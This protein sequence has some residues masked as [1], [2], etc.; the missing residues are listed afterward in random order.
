[1]NRFR[2]VAAVTA[3]A[4]LLVF[5]AGLFAAAKAG[6]SPGALS[7]AEEERI[8]PE[9]SREGVLDGSFQ[10][11]LDSYIEQKLPGRTLMVKVR[12]QLLYSLFG[13]S[14]NSRFTLGKD[15]YL[16]SRSNIT[17]YLQYN[18]IITE[19]EAED[20]VNKIVRVRDI[21][22]DAGKQTCVFVTPAKIRFCRDKLPRAAEMSLPEQQADDYTVLMKALRKTDLPYFDSVEWLGE[23]AGELDGRVPLFF[24]T[25]HHWSVYVGNTVGA[26]FADFLEEKSGYNLPEIEVEAG[27]VSEPVFPDADLYNAL[28]L[29]EKPKEQYYEPLITVTDP[30][31]D[32]P[33]IFIRGGSFMGQ[34]ISAL[35]RQ[36]YFGKN[37]YFENT[38]LFTDKFSDYTYVT[39]YADVDLLEYLRDTDLFVLEINECSVW[40]M[41]F[42]FLDWVLEHE[43]E[44]RAL[45][46]EGEA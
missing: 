13:I 41:S 29:F 2:Y 24:R 38:S 7:G 26:A 23:H 8:F 14:P 33:G 20:R 39:D 30:E 17:N 32:A 28:N 16:F 5:P 6:I 46:E 12:N 4:L 44:V 21:M 35:I 11:E 18:G 42:G 25:G 45:G 36:D 22:A 43:E 34:S 15:G 19:Q 10:G 40:D 27:P 37:V 3:A 1:M 31:T 9:F